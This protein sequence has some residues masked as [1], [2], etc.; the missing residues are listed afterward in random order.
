MNSYFLNATL[1]HDAEIYLLLHKDQI[2]QSVLQI[3]DAITEEKQIAQVQD[4]CD[5]ISISKIIPF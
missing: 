4:I 3:I 2:D 1:T 5:A